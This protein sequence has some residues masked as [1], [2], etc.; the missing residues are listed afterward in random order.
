MA[1]ATLKPSRARQYILS[2]EI[3][4]TFAHTAD[5]AVAIPAV[6]LPFG[7]QVVGGAV[8]VDTAFNAGTSIVLDVGDAT[9]A[10][11]YKNDVNLAATGVTA[12]VP[13]GYVS[14]GGNINITPVIVGAAAT[15]GAARLRVDYVIAGR[16]Q[17]VQTN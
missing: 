2:A 11:R 16:A 17:E 12:L 13:T 1:N 7:A 5:T 14:D 8:V 6:L 15:V 4:F 10:N 3:A 9:V